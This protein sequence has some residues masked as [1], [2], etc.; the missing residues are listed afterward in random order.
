MR[1]ASMRKAEIA[2]FVALIITDAKKQVN[3]QGIIII[4]VGQVI[5][6]KTHTK[7]GRLAANARIS[8]DD[9]L[10]QSGGEG[11]AQPLHVEMDMY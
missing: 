2:R 8:D 11:V 4:V 9:E 3:V 7:V 5:Y 6:I 1:M 10:L